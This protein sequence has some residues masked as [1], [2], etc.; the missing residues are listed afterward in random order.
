MYNSLSGYS[1]LLVT[2]S[3]LFILS[4]AGD[5]NQGHENDRKVFYH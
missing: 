2:I 1:V 5:S 4:G 3:V